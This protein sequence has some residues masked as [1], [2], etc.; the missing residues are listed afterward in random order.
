MENCYVF[1][2]GSTKTALIYKQNGE[3]HELTLPGF[4]PNVENDDF[5]KEL[6]SSLTIPAEAEIIFYGS[7]L[8]NEEN[9]NVVRSI[10]EPFA[11]SRIKVFDDILGAARSVFKNDAGIICIM[12]TG[13][14]AAYYNG[15]EIV[16]RRGGYGYLID[17]LGGGF[18]L[19]RR[20]IS[21]WRKGDLSESISNELEIK[22]GSDAISYSA[23]IY[24][25]KDLRLIS[26]VVPLIVDYKE[27]TFFS[28]FLSRYFSDFIDQ[29][30]LPLYT[31]FGINKVSVVG[32]LGTAFYKVLRDELKL[33][34]LQLEQCVQNPIQRLFE[35]HQH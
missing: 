25:T 30:I 28:Q 15:K 8:A 3:K 19:G 21:S 4:N 6:K 29:D 23:K 20:F 9:K 2:A 18:E 1:E 10:F 24:E 5:I 13:G 31:Q 11:P 34:G 33:H 26:G 14:L 16:K 22:L 32:S 17:D 7:G 35:Y 27:D 12:G